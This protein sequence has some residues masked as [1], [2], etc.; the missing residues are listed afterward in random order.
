MS[1][2]A[3]SAMHAFRRLGRAGRRAVAL[4]GKLD[5]LDG[6]ESVELTLIRCVF[7]VQPLRGGWLSLLTGSLGEFEIREFLNVNYENFP[8]A[9]AF[10]VAFRIV[11]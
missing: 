11:C 10:V 5:S 6:T 7:N 3:C 8:D 2:A 1:R 9:F 4:L